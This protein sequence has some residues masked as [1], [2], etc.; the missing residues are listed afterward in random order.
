M[1]VHT[2]CIFNNF[3]KKEKNHQK[4]V[5][6]AFLNVRL[7]SINTRNFSNYLGLASLVMFIRLQS[8]NSRHLPREEQ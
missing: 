4:S 7:H 2:F 3:F 1:L 8:Q 6:N 5:V